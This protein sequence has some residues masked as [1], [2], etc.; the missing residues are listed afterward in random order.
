MTM[1]DQRLDKFGCRDW[2]AVGRS[3]HRNPASLDRPGPFFNLG[4][5]EFLQ[6]I[7]RA[8][9]VRDEVGADLPHPRLHGGGG[10]GRERGGMKLVDDCRGRSFWGGGGKPARGVGNGSTVLLRRS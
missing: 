2:R 5:D 9:L 6:I 8:A 1:I 10:D 7:G 4:L 3:I